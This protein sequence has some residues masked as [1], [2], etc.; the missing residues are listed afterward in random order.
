MDMVRKF[1]ATHQGRGSPKCPVAACGHYVMPNELL[2]DKE[3]ERKMKSAKRRK[4][5]PTQEDAQDVIDL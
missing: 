4:R 1:R 5:R 2:P 3:M